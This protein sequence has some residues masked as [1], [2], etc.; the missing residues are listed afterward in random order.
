[1][2]REAPPERLIVAEVTKPHGIRGEVSARLADVSGADLVGLDLSLRIGD[3]PETPVRIERARP[4]GGAWILALAGVAD[5]NRAG[6]LRGAVLL[7]ARADLPEPDDGEWWV[8]DLVGRTVE[9][10]ELGGIG[11][12]EEVLKLPA[13]DVL[14]V[15]G[16]L[17]E[18]LVPVLEDVV[19]D[20]DPEADVLRVRLPKGLLDPVTDAPGEDG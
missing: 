14:V 7:A 8:A 6:E 19:L 10:A 15:R 1:M 4:A 18:V 2:T 9:D 20:A 3:G 11:R 13:N 5:R 17:G 12:I 16:R